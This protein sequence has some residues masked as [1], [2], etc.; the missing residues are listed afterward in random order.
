MA[1]QEGGGLCFFNV[2]LL[3]A[4]LGFSGSLGFTAWL[5]AAF[6]LRASLIP[7]GL[8]RRVW[9][10]L[11]GALSAHKMFLSRCF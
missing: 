3:T 9:R 8:V 2:S 5:G 6:A 11:R 1:W 7:A 10:V 4:P